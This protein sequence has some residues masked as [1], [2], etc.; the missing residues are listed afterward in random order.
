VIGVAIVPWSHVVDRFSMNP[1]GMVIGVLECERTRA[2]NRLLKM[3]RELR[4][5]INNPLSSIYS[6]LKVAAT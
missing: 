1:F 4:H 6:D 2:A 3:G 5:S